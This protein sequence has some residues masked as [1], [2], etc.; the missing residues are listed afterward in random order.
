MEEGTVLLLLFALLGTASALSFYGNS[1]SFGTPKKHSDGT[2]EVQDLCHFLFNIS[3]LQN[4][5]NCKCYHNIGG[6][7]EK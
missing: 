1:I 4:K 6:V 7:P 5:E 3:F 2:F